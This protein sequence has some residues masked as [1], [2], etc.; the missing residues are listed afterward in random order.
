[1]ASVFFQRIERDLLCRVVNDHGNRQVIIEI[2]GI[3]LDS[4]LLDLGDLISKLTYYLLVA[5]DTP[6]DFYD[7]LVPPLHLLVL[8]E[9]DLVDDFDGE[10]LELVLLVLVVNLLEDLLQVARVE[11]ERVFVHLLKL[12]RLVVERGGVLHEFEDRKFLVPVEVV[13]AVEFFGLQEEFYQVVLAFQQKL[14][15]LSKLAHHRD[16][17]VLF[18]DFLYLVL[19]L[20]VVDQN[21]LANLSVLH[22]EK[23]R[24]LVNIENPGVRRKEE[25]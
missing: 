7:E 14:L 1:M 11:G 24:F 25:K 8:L 20:L 12:L 22:F 13:E 19:V 17:E 16:L 4:R 23:A 21:M 15:L 2:Y 5:L 9:D 6:V 10:Q 3:L 18:L